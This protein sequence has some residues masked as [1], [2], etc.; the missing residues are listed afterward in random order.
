LVLIMGHK[1][2]H[3]MFFTSAFARLLTFG[4]YVLTAFASMSYAPCNEHWSLVRDFGPQR[5][6][7]QG[8]AQAPRR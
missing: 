1:V 8:K 3:P 5:K 4:H 7:H 2:V 6:A